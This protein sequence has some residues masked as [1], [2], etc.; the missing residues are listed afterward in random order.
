MNGVT[1]HFPPF[2][3]SDGSFSFIADEEHFSRVLELTAH[4]QRSLWLGTAD[5]KDLHVASAGG[6]RQRPYLGV[7][8]DLLGRGVE[9]RLIHAK[10]PGPNFRADFDRFPLLA[11]RLERVLCPRVHFKL[12]IIDSTTCYI[13]SANLTGAGMGM[14]SPHRRNFEAGILTTEPGIVRAAMEEFDKVWRG[15]CCP[16]CGRRA[17]CPDPVC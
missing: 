1:S 16:S 10:E 3:V 4:A 14:K 7:L 6:R 5:V 9:L 15:D 8:A 13:G 17:T 12:I 11:T 2:P